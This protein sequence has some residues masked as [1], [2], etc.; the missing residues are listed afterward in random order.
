MTSE[1]D[2]APSTRHPPVFTEELSSV[3]SDYVAMQPSIRPDP[4]FRLEEDVHETA[5]GEETEKFLKH[6]HFSKGWRRMFWKV[7]SEKYPVGWEDEL[8]AYMQHERSGDEQLISAD[9]AKQAVKAMRRDPHLP[10]ITSDS[11]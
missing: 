10:S 4:L 3:S 1:I 11:M 2:H 9:W 5:F 6:V 7:F 8:Y